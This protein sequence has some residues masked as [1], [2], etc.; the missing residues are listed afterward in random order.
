MSEVLRKNKKQ[1]KSESGFSLVETVPIL[2]VI[3]SLIGFL[4]GL[5]GLAHK[6][7]IGSISAR[8][9]AFETFNH[10]SNLI[11]FNDLRSESNSYER[12]NIR[13]HGY[14][15]GD[16]GDIRAMTTPFRFPA[17]ENAVSYTHLT[18]PTIYSV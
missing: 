17:E 11:Y 9:Y 13:F 10:R 8:N 14:G 3:S 12:S 2:F 16:A 1:K 5:W 18:L 6:N 15:D 7:V 4:L